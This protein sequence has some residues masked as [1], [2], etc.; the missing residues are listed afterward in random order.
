[1]EV[2]EE[3]KEKKREGRV[4]DWRGNNNYYYN[5]THSNVYGDVIMAEPLREFIRFI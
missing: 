3:I 4:R 5:N 2:K 1:M